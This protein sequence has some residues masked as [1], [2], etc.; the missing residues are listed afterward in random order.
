MRKAT[1]ERK[2]GFP[3]GPTGLMARFF[4]GYL[5]PSYTGGVVS[6]FKS[7]EASRCGA[8][9]RRSGRM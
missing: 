7:G 6:T 9:S 8:R 5:Y 2:L 1:G 4:Q 3:A